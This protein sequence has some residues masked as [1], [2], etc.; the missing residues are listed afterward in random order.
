M[1]LCDKIVCIHVQVHIVNVVMIQ[2]KMGMAKYSL[3]IDVYHNDSIG[4]INIFDMFRLCV[5]VFNA[6][7]YVCSCNINLYIIHTQIRCEF[8]FSA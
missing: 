7:E 4:Q 1:N 8:L 3:S 6:F 2:P 5:C